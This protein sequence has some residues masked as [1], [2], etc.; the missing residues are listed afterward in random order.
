[1]NITKQQFL[2]YTSGLVTTVFAALA[3]LDPSIKISPSARGAVVSVLGVVGGGV[4]SFYNHSSH[5]KE[6][7]ELAH[8]V[9][10]VIKEVE[11][12]VQSRS[13]PPNT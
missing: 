7:A 5:K 10:P 11:A 2:T 3:L 12:V 9:A 1:M 8:K 6:I 4:V 13:D